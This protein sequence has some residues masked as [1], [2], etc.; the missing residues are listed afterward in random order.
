MT[1]E[2]YMKRA[3]DRLIAEILE[4][5]PALMVVGPRASGKTTTAA[6]HAATVVRLDQVG[7][8]AAFRN[9]PDA[10]LRSLKEPILLDEWQVVPDVLGAVKRAVDTDFRP[11]RFILA[12]SVR[13]QL[14]VPMWPGTGRVVRVP[15]YGLTVAELEGRPEAKPLLDRLVHGEDPVVP[16]NPPDLRGYVEIALRSGYPEAA[17]A[18]TQRARTRWLDGY[19]NHTMERDAVEES[20]LRDPDKFRKF[21]EAY[22][23]NSAGMVEDRTLYEAAGL[24][25]KTGVAY[26]QV[27]VNLFMADRLPAW[28]TN[29]LKRLILS[30][31]RYLIDPALVAGVLGLD[32]AAVMRNGDLLGRIIETFVVSQVRS[33]MANTESRARLYHMRQRE[34]R[35]E[36]DLIAEIGGTRI[37]GIEIKSTAAP[38]TEDAKHLFWLRDQLGDRFVRGV[39]LHTGKRVFELGDRVQAVPIAALWGD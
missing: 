17:L 27:M 36:V 16:D 9:D 29:R 32:V 26:E 14:D 2:P 23:L 10:A 24:N 1:A 25:R 22:A 18:P 5:L 20:G 31:K 35:H 21:F 13:A 30:P 4:E 34:G 19:L 28:T 38:N 8:A 12:G 11:G 33:G 15:M 39:V 6:R 3:S 7:E 37:V